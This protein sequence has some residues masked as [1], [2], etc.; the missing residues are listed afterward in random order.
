MHVQTYGNSLKVIRLIANIVR[1][2]NALLD[3]YLA[4]YKEVFWA[5]YYFYI[6]PY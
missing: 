4:F 5:L 2:T 1:I 6:L 3:T